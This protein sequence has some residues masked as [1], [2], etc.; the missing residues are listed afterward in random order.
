MHI[1]QSQGQTQGLQEALRLAQ[2]AAQRL[3][4][5]AAVQAAL[6]LALDW[7]GRLIEAIEA[8][9]RA[10]EL[11]PNYAEG[12]PEVINLTA[13]QYIGRILQVA[14]DPAVPEDLAQ[15]FEIILPLSREVP[16]K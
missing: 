4:E 13:D 5:S 15:P 3:P 9:Q 7:N 1:I 11:D 12:Y 10:V 16:F 6:C 2:K 8:G 14:I